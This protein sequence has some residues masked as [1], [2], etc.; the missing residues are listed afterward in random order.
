MPP[1]PQGKSSSDL[2][3]PALAGRTIV[4]TGAAR[5]LG[6]T[7]TE[8]CAGAGA[9]LVLADVLTDAGR[10][11]AEALAA[12]GC[13]ARFIPL[14]LGDPDSVKRFAADIAAREG[15]AHGLVNNAAVATAIGGPTFEEIELDV[16]ERVMRINVRGTWLVTRALAPLLRASGTGRIVNLASDT[17]LWGAPRLL[18]YVASKGAVMAMTRSLARELGP[19]RVGVAAVAP[20]IV[21]T[22][23]TDY[24]PAERHRL[25]ETG[26]AVPGPQVPEDITATVVFLLTP[27][28]LAVTGQTV[29]VNAGF[30]FT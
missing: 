19:D 21:R 10:A 20:G 2:V 29:P 15:V 26:R 28:A 14:D 24:V 4:V 30:V 6:K 25:Y 5:G 8:A 7:I 16:W 9:R 18:A 11:A 17:A 3:A 13:E 12:R 22:E 27:G 23:A 1:L